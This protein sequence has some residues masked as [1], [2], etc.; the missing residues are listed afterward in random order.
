MNN[1]S[2]P[3]I[4]SFLDYRVIN[5]EFHLNEDFVDTGEPIELNFSLGHGFTT[6][7]NNIYVNL[8]VRVFEKAE[9]NNYPFEIS[10]DMQGIF[11]S[12]DADINLE[13]FLPNALA[14]LYPY[15]RS[16]IS[17]YTANANVQPLVLPT[18][19]MMNYINEK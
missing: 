18:V 15:A 6:L 16:L 10:V 8:G 4:I 1:D 7:D 19:N 13:D 9:E 17:S 2:Y 14:I 5:V 3:G 12:E 11:A